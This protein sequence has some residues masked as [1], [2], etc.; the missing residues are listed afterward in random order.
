MDASTPCEDWK[1][2][3]VVDPLHLQSSAHLVVAL[4]SVKR[5]YSNRYT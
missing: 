5:C 3:A 2:K 4:S 1:G